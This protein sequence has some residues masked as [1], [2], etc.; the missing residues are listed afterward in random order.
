MRKQVIKT[1]TLKEIIKTKKQKL[2]D[3]QLIKNNN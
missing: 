2:L 1:K 3:F